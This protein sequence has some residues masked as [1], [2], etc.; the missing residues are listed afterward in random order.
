VKNKLKY[1]LD[2]FNDDTMYYAASL[3]F[4][5]IFSLLPIVALLIV[6]MSS[7][8]YFSSYIDILMS[9][10]YDFINPTHSSE[11]IL[12]IQNALT[13][14]NSLGNIGLVYLFFIFTMFFKDYEYIMSKIHKTK[15]RPIIKM[16]LLYLSFLIIIP[17]TILVITFVMSYFQN[18][19]LIYILNFIFS[20]FILSILFKISVNKFVSIKAS[21]IASFITV[22]V[23]KLTQALFVYYIAYNTTY[24]T[25]YGTL[26]AMLFMFL[27]IYMSWIIYLYGVKI[28]H[29]LNIG[30]KNAK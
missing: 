2:F 21:F 16:L 29:R 6:V 14:I 8:I 7:T 26:S 15:K 20:V 24:T 19:L 5:T 11:V 30:E 25:I 3:S 22:S 9:Y 1:I 27:W 13:N 18:T 23:L 17:F 10:I 28:S 4:F 12:T